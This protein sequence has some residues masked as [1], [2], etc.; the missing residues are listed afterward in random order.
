MKTI[1][2][3]CHG[4]II[5]IC[6]DTND[7]KSIRQM[8]EA[9]TVCAAKKNKKEYIGKCVGNIDIKIS[10]TM[11]YKIVVSCSYFTS[12]ISSLKNFMLLFIFAGWCSLPE[13]V[14]QSTPSC[15]GIHTVTSNTSYYM[16]VKC[17]TNEVIAIIDATVSFPYAADNCTTANAFQNLLKF[18]EC[19]LLTNCTYDYALTLT[20]SSTDVGTLNEQCNGK[21]ICQKFP[22]QVLNNAQCDLPIYDKILN[23]MALNHY[24]IKSKFMVKSIYPVTFFLLFYGFHVLSDC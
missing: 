24:C 1:K 9:K 11:Y 14:N 21:S 5:C 22:V 4:C 20:Q 3:L 13:S 12:V 15:F 16:N 18:T 10:P 8:N 6:F 2:A 17:P 23:S 7:L 19:C